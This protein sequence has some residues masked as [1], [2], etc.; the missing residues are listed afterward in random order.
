MSLYVQLIQIR[1]K[2]KII[3]SYR[4][5]HPLLLQW[6]QKNKHNTR[7]NPHALQRITTAFLLRSEMLNKKC[8]PP[9]S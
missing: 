9:A 1:I 6:L 2:S 5:C 4:T 7:E 3:E 8:I